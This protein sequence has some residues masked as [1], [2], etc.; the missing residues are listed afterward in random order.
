MNAAAGLPLRQLGHRLRRLRRPCPTWPPCASSRGSSAPRWC[1]ATCWSR[2]PTDP[3]EVS[4]RQILQRQV[5]RAAERGLHGQDR[6]RARVLPVQ[7][8]LRRG[9]ARS[10]TATSRPHSDW[11]EDY[12][13][14]QTTRDEYII[15]ADPQ[16]DGRRRACRS[17]SP[18]AR[19][20]G[21]STR[22]TCVYADALEMADRHTIY[23]NGA[24]EIADANGR[25]ITFMAKWTIDEVG[26]SCHIHS[27][28]VGRRRDD[29]RWLWP[30]PTPA[31]RPVARPFR[32]W[33]GGL[34]AASR[35]LTW[36]FA[37]TVNSY[38][39]FQPDS[40]APTAVAWGARQPHLR[41]AHRGP[42]PPPPGRVPHPGRRRQPVPRLRRGDR[43]R[44]PRHRARARPGPGVR[45][46]RLRRPPTSSGSR[47]PWSRP[48]TCSRR[49]RWPATPSVDDVHHHL[50]NTA[51][52]EWLAFNPG[53]HRLGAA[54]G[55]RAPVTR[56][57][58]H[59]PSPGRAP[60]CRPPSAHRWWPCPAGSSR[61]SASSGPWSPRPASRPTT[62]SPWVGPARSGALLLPKAATDDAAVDVLAPVRRPRADRW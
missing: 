53:R 45:G 11:I 40:W 39:R 44:P 59:R 33:L 60:S 27:S 30:T 16:R 43:R 17:S 15:R 36:L 42:R 61:P 51:R 41:A 22:S 3:V 56:H 2:A 6:R 31:R 23:K 12:H 4:P 10:A 55:V 47:R 49:P 18:R 35:E 9:R 24:K 29:R 21:A 58:A 5:E 28:R 62:W 37:P 34:V 8:L 48:S 57:L 7:G 50:L 52:Q 26:S 46:Q 1:C 13:V 19:P 32:H 38:K 20:A 14:L 54:P 25:A